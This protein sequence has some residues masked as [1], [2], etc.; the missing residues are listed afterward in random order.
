MSE[1]KPLAASLFR[2]ITKLKYN[3]LK[4]ANYAQATLT[5]NKNHLTNHFFVLTLNKYSAWCTSSCIHIA[6][7]I[8]SWNVQTT[9]YSK[10]YKHCSQTKAK[11]T[12]KFDVLPQGF[13]S[14]WLGILLLPRH[15][16]LLA[17]YIAVATFLHLIGQFR[18]LFNALPLD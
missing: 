13:P 14:T 8:V 11:V 5:Q 7:A 12:K 3:E 4:I 17:L 10:L 2:L 6:G 16:C 18:L 15:C 9:Y 1:L